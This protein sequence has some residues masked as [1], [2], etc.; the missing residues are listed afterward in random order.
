M[1]PIPVP[2]VSGTAKTSTSQEGPVAS[3]SRQFIPPPDPCLEFVR[4]DFVQRSI[5]NKGF[6]VQVAKMAAGCHKKSTTD[7]YQNR[8]KLYREWCGG[9]G[10]PP[11]NPSI[12]NLADFFVYLYVSK[13]L[14]PSAIKGYRSMLISSLKHTGLEITNNHTIQDIF[15]SI[16]INAPRVDRSLVSWNLNIVLQ[17]LMGPPFEPLARASTKNAMR[18]ALFLMIV[19][20]SKRVGEIQTYSN[21]VGYKRRDMIL[22]YLP[23]FSAKTETEKNKLP[24]YVQIPSLDNILDKEDKDRLNCPVRALK[25]YLDRFKDAHNR[26]KNLFCSFKDPSRAA[27]KNAMSYMNRMLIKEAHKELDEKWF[28]LCKVKTH[29]VRGVGRLHLLCLTTTEV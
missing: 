6:S 22:S 4:V 23:G 11:S 18:K 14:S 1:V 5:S 26:S 7:A 2:S 27:S 16:D 29:D 3:T 19:A 9:Q 12:I 25:Y 8:W 17:Y 15:R 13:K 21:D 20:T 10:I 24:R 28:P